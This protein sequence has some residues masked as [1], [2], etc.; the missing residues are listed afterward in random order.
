M[1]KEIPDKWSLL[2]CFLF[3]AVYAA[4]VYLVNTKQ[5]PVSRKE[6][7]VM[8]KGPVVFG[9]ILA[10]CIAA[11]CAS[12]AMS[13]TV[14]WTISEQLDLKAPP[15]DMCASAD[16]KWL[17]I[18]SAGEVVVYSFADEKI[19]NR[20]SID[21]AFDRMVYVRKKNALIVTSHSDNQV[22]IIQL[23]EVHAFS[24]SGLPYQGPKG[25]PVV[26]AVFSDYQ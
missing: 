21:T 10:V 15:V 25:A 8:K 24:Y 16:G 12:P 18:L 5:Q 6:G 2:L 4:G 17:Y 20:I 13:A 26:I 3:A 9:I 1:S 11:V 22:R 7:W 19:V 14:E 23:E